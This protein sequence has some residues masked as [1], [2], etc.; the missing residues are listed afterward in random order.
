MATKKEI[1]EQGKLAAKQANYTQKMSEDIG[2]FVEG[3][4]FRNKMEQGKIDKAAGIDKDAKEARSK[5]VAILKNISL[6]EQKR[7]EDFDADIKAREASLEK[8]GES[9]GKDSG[10]F[11]KANKALEEEKAAEEARRE[12][13]G[14]NML[15]RIAKGI[16]GISGKFKDFVGETPTALKAILAGVAFF[17]LAKFLKSPQFQKITSFIVDSLLPALKDFFDDIMKFDFELTGENGLIALIKNNFGVIIGALAI[18]KPKL[19]F[20]LAKFAFMGLFNGIKFMYM[21]MQKNAFGGR[22]MKTKRL[23]SLFRIRTLAVASGFGK[24]GAML[25]GAM[26]KTMGFLTKGIGFMMKGLTFLG[27]GILSLGKGLLFNPIGL[28]I[29]AIVGIVAAIVYYFDDIK[30]YFEE[31]GGFAGI[32]SRVIANIKDALAGVANKFITAY[33]FVTN[34]DVPLFETGRA[35]A[36]AERIEKE[37]VIKKQADAKKKAEADSKKKQDDLFAEGT[38][39]SDLPAEKQ[40]TA[41]EIQANAID[42]LFGVMKP[43]S[44][45]I[46]QTNVN[47]SKVSNAKNVTSKAVSSVDTDPIYQITKNVSIA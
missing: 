15:G 40:L 6:A 8:L 18:L 22:F 13:Q 43:Q 9:I 16:E 10:T 41:G 39:G 1:Q 38:M 45:P 34:S 26:A 36:N 25:G 12:K 7:Q 31:L 24:A 32:F 29:L 42:K 33:N 37:N 35:E 23:L 27:K 4:K 21:D 19:L 44:S 47:N 17:A 11:K 20:N 30:S 28:I 5:Q 2:A 46:I 3:Q 14:Q